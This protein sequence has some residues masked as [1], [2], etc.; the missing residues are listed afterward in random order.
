MSERDRWKRPDQTLPT[1]LDF[2]K[3]RVAKSEERQW[4]PRIVRDSYHYTED[5]KQQII[6][7]VLQRVSQGRTAMGALEELPNHPSW[8]A[9]NSWLR[10][11]PD[12]MAAY[13]DA[14]DVGFDAMAQDALRIAD[15]PVTEYIRVESERGTTI[16]ER[17][18]LNHRKLQI[19]TRMRLLERWCP[20]RYGARA[21]VSHDVAEGGALGDFLKNLSTSA[22]PIV[23]S[24]VVPGPADRSAATAAEPQSGSALA[25]RAEKGDPPG[26]VPPREGPAVPP[27]DHD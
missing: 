17:D 1:Q 8:M 12:Y 22:L 6:D 25:F 15:T 26:A 10:R 7:Y 11:N 14:R 27:Y 5:E 18:A 20:A 19:D 3:G 24:T 16:T 4:I 2:L 9:F 21:Q 23:G 13:L